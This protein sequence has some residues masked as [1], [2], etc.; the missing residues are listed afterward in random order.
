MKIYKF[1]V[2]KFAKNVICIP[3][4]LKAK[5][6]QKENKN[7]LSPI[8]NLLKSEKLAESTNE[9]LN[10]EEKRD[11]ETLLKDSSKVMLM[12]FYKIYEDKAVRIKETKNLY[13][14][15]NKT[16]NYKEVNLFIIYIKEIKRI[17]DS[18]EIEKTE[19][20]FKM[21]LDKIYNISSNKG[22]FLYN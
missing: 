5:N 9:K 6:P 8:Y 3:P 17:I 21:F 11:Y 13:D 7:K 22:I 4:K 15:V 10:V 16:L 2:R 12:N 19:E 20:V 14:L 18:E 1:V